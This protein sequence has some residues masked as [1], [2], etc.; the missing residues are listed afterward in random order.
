MP[1]SLIFLPCIPCY[2]LCW[3]PF[4]LPYL[5]LFSLATGKLLVKAIVATIFHTGIST[6]IE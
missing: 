3:H 2:F 6:G 1:I 5:F 4:T